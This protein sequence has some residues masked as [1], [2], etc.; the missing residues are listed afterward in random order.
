[1]DNTSTTDQTNW[2]VPAVYRVVLKREGSIA[3][4]PEL[5]GPD[6][7]SEAL[8]TYLRDADR[9]VCAVAMLDVDDRLIGISVVAIGTLTMCPAHPREILKVALLCNAAAIILAHNHPVAEARPSV[10]DLDL[11][12]AIGEVS[13]ALGIQLLDHLIIG[14]E[15][16][17]SMSLNRTWRIED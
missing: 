12:E 7:A 13:L 16:T 5:S 8:R 10:A 9:E 15:E 3:N 14:A 1:M 11:T 2:L 17:H 6:A 4:R